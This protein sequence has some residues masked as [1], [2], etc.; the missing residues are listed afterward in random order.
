MDAETTHEVIEGNVVWDCNSPRIDNESGGPSHNEWG[1]NV[2][3][4]E[5]EEPA[6]ASRL[7]D[8]ITARR[9]KGLQS[10]DVAAAP[11]RPGYQIGYSAHRTNLPGGQFANCATTRACVVEGD[12]S[13]TRELGAEWARKPNQRVQFAGWSPDGRQAILLQGW[14]S[15]ENGRWEHEHKEFRFTAE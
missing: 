11:E 2:L 15:E 5:K 9:Q 10:P 1:D 13:G 12:G 8:S 6:Q 14:E 7:R 4:G 3:S